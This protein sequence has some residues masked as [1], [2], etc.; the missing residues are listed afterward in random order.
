MDGLY[1]G[2][3]RSKMVPNQPARSLHM[4]D[5]VRHALG[6]PSSTATLY[7]C[8]DCGTVVPRDDAECPACGSSEVAAYE[9]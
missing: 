9:L 5:T 2:S 8:R 3:K 6:R 7:E 1:V 4:L